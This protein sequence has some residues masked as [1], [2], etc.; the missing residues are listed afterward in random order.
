VQV[1]IVAEL[2]SSIGLIVW[3]TA[4]GLA[5]GW[6]IAVL[7]PP[8]RQ[9]WLAIAIRGNVPLESRRVAIRSDCPSSGHRATCRRRWAAGGKFMMQPHDGS[10]LA[11]GLARATAV[12]D[13]ACFRYLAEAGLVGLRRQIER[14]ARLLGRAAISSA[15]D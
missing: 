8:R 2:R 14:D 10:A 4:R 11:R 15:V 9:T 12:D 3:G 7:R 13:A 6:V 5:G 1:A